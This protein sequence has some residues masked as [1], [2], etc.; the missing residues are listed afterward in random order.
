MLSPSDAAVLQL[1]HTPKVGAR[2]LE[3]VL[4]AVAAEGVPPEEVVSGPPSAL[5]RFGL[6]AVSPE[7]LAAARDQ[8]DRLGGQMEEHGIY[9]LVKGGPGYLPSLAGKGAPPVLFARGP[10]GIVERKAVAF[11]GARDAS[12]KGR[13]IARVCA[14]ALA[15]RGVNIVSGY[16]NGVDLVAHAAA[17]TANGVTTLVLAEGILRF[18]AKPEVTGLLT[19]ANH[20]ILSQFPPRLPWSVGNAMQRNATVLGLA[21]AV[22][23]IESGESGGTFAAAEA[24][25]AMG[26][27]LFVVDFADPPPSAAGN[28]H[29]LDRG[30]A[31]LRMGPDGSPN[32]REVWKF[33]DGGS[34]GGTPPD[35]APVQRTLFE[36]LE[37]AG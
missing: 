5:S 3:K 12:P 14:E 24:A 36:P 19:D 15:A 25:L 1:M 31:P 18:K 30:A 2:T 28:R 17:L 20:M 23:V 11:C 7:S 29:F 21:D 16:A 6:T 27:P 9:L 26:R 4:A 35:S 34:L 33:L 8:A 13:Q 32:L 22:L 37:D 10:R